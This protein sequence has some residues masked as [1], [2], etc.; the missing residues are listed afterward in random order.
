MPARVAGI[1]G[2]VAFVTVNIGWIAGVRLLQKADSPTA[3]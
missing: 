1:C 3:S 2:L